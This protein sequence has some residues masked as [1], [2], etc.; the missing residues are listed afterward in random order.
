MCLRWKYSRLKVHSFV[1]LFLM[2]SNSVCYFVCLLVYTLILSYMCCAGCHGFPRY[3]IAFLII[4]AVHGF[5]H[6]Y[7]SRLMKT[8]F[9]KI[10]PWPSA[11]SGQR[12]SLTVDKF[13]GML[14]FSPQSLI[15]SFCTLLPFCLFHLSE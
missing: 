6:V 15:F 7:M 3:V 8:M 5:I 10:P 4:L 1:L 13:K 9:M 2:N 12:L 11:F 14:V